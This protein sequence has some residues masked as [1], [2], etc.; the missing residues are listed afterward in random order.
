[1]Q[2]NVTDAQADQILNALAQRPYAESALLINELVLQVNKQKQGP[3]TGN[4]IPGGAVA[5][6]GAGASPVQ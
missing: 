4:A 5:V 3:Q 2:F 6:N 1:M